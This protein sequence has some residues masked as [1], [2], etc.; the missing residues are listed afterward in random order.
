M[1]NSRLPLYAPRMAPAMTRFNAGDRVGLYKIE[2]ELATDA[3]GISYRAVHQV[4]PRR[5][6]VKV[7]HAASVYPPAIKQPLAVHVLREACI[8]EAL[9]HPGVSR[10]YESGLLRERRPWFARELVEGVT[11]AL[12]LEQSIDPSDAISILRD[13]T[14]CSITRIAAASSIVALRPDRVVLTDATRGYPICITDWSHARAHDAAP[15]GPYS[16]PAASWHYTSPELACGDPIDDR[17]DVFALGVIAYQLLTN[18]LPF[19]GEGIAMMHDGSRQHVPV[20]DSCPDLPRELT[21]LVDSML[22]YDRWDRPP[23]AE[24]HEDLTWLADALRDTTGV[25][26]ARELARPHPAPALDAE[27][28]RHGWRETEYDLEVILTEDTS[29][30]E[31]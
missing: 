15:F 16:P 26:R 24:V 10:V 12:L 23:L 2:S 7:M 30:P 28:R 8:L 1:I 6:I 25:V 17:T 22:A 19:D 14:R 5:A 21:A 20:E 3:S 13:V 11:V 9:Q 27:R 18:R 31:R 29:D 4:L